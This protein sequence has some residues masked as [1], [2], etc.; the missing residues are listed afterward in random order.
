MKILKKKIPM[1][2]TI[3]HTTLP[4][5]ESKLNSKLYFKIFITITISVIVVIKIW[6]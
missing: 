4:K 6:F 1:T 5:Q 2:E 3:Y